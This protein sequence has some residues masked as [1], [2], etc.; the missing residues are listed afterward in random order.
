MNIHFR[1]HRQ[2]LPLIV[3]IVLF[4]GIGLIGWLGIA[5]FHTFIEEKAIGI[6]EYH[7][8]RENRERQIGKLPDL[9]SQF[10]E[11]V[12]HDKT[13]DILLSENRIVDFVK[14][15]ESLAKQT[16]TRIS[17]EA[18][19]KDAIQE[20]KAVRPAKKTAE[21]DAE[22]ETIKKKAP[23]TMLESIPYDRYLH[24][25]VIVEGEYQNIVSFL[26][27]METL[28]L[29]LDVIG[30]SIRTREVTEIAEKPDNPGR[31]PFLILSQGTSPT[32]PVI[33]I[34]EPEQKAPE[35]SLEATFDTVIYVSKE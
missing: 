3:M 33:P 35:G 18:K 14:T 5:P 34:V 16:N 19:D 24:V 27:K 32:E 6:Q 2:S 12:E 31:N 21:A 7:A 15:L 23:L 9:Q 8:S 20:K 4:L 30:L 10:E 17:I 25:S 11:I 26:H 22:E 29:G 28:P 13:L 1:Q